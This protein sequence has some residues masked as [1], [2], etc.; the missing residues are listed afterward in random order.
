MKCDYKV[1]RISGDLEKYLNEKGSQGWRCV[2]V[3]TATGLGLTH[4]IV[5][6]RAVEDQPIDTVIKIIE[7]K[8]KE[9]DDKKLNEKATHDSNFEEHITEQKVEFTLNGK[10][11]EILEMAARFCVAFECT[12]ITMNIVFPFLY[13]LLDADYSI[14][15]KGIQINPIQWILL[16]IAVFVSLILLFILE[17][18]HDDEQDKKGE[19]K[20]DEIRI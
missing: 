11:K 15:E 3:T 7:S 2:S 20:K 8:S 1:K 9:D 18:D 10:T 17:K 4:I 19:I 13:S 5:L 16:F 12:W 6:E 14:M